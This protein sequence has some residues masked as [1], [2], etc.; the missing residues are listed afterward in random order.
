MFYGY[1]DKNSS[2]DIFPDLTSCNLSVISDFEKREALPLTEACC[3]VSLGP[4]CGKPRTLC[5]SP[6]RRHA[7]AIAQMS[8][9][10][11][12]IKRTDTLPHKILHEL[13]TQEQ[14]GYH[15]LNLFFNANNTHPHEAGR[16]T[17]FLIEQ[18]QI[19]VLV[20]VP[21]D[22]IT[23]NGGSGEYIKRLGSKATIEGKE[24]DFSLSTVNML[25]VITP[26]GVEAYYRTIDSEQRRLLDR[27]GFVVAIIVLVA[28]I[29]GAAAAIIQASTPTQVEVL[30]VP[31]AQEPQEDSFPPVSQEP[32]PTLPDSS[33]TERDSK[34]SDTILSVHDT[35]VSTKSAPRR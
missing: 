8:K 15:S 32:N 24:Y 34:T 22:F 35:V 16:I 30:S 9:K 25:T 19:T 33:G 4:P 26:T 27:Y 6:I 31:Q 23:I 18:K 3:K 11:K 20:T 28:T 7:V 21:N 17:S 29:A 1:M 13:M 14:A 2:L 12:V 5:H 10:K